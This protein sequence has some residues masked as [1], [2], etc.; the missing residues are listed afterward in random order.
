MSNISKITN[1]TVY[2]EGDGI[3]FQT[4]YETASQ[5]PCP[6]GFHI[7]T[8]DEMQFVFD[9]LKTL[10]GGTVTVQNLQDHL[11]M[12][13]VGYID[14]QTGQPSTSYGVV[15]IWT[16]TFSSAQCY[17]FKDDTGGVGVGLDRPATGMQLRPFA[18]QPVIP[19]TGWTT[20][21]SSGT[22]SLSVN[23]TLGLMTITDGEKYI[24]F[25]DKNLGATA[26]YDGTV[27]AANTGHYYQAGNNYGFDTP[28]TNTS[29]TKVN[30]T[31]YWP[32]NYYNSDT[33]ICGTNI[34]D[35]RT[36]SN[37]NLW[38]GVGIQRG[39]SINVDRSILD[40]GIKIVD[41]F[42]ENPETGDIVILS[43]DAKTYKFGSSTTTAYLCYNNEN[44]GA[45]D[46]SPKVWSVAYYRADSSSPY[47]VDE[48]AAGSSSMYLTL[49]NHPEVWRFDRYS[50]YLQSE[51]T[52]IAWVDANIDTD[53]DTD[54]LVDLKDT[55]IASAK[56]EDIINYDSS[57][58]KYVN[59][60][61]ITDEVVS[62]NTYNAITKKD[63]RIYFVTK[64]SGGFWLDKIMYRWM[65]LRPGIE[66][67]EVEDGI[68]TLQRADA[69]GKIRVPAATNTWK[70]TIDNVVVQDGTGTASAEFSWYTPD[71]S[72][73]VVVEP[74]TA[75][76]YKW[77][78]SYKR[79]NKPR[80]NSI[81]ALYQNTFIWYA[82]S[83]TTIGADYQMEQFYT[84]ENLIYI[85]EEEEDIPDTVT[86]IGN[87]FKRAQFGGCSSLKNASREKFG[88]NITTISNYFRQSQYSGSAIEVASPEVLNDK[89][90]QI[91]NYFRTQQYNSCRK[92][93]KIYNEAMPNTVTNIG[94]YFRSQQFTY[95]K[96]L[97]T[98]ATEALSNSVTSI[99][100]Y[101]RQSQYAYSGVTAASAE[102]FPNWVT[103]IW[104]SFRNGQYTNCGSLTAAAN[105]VM[106]D[107][108][109]NV[110]N[111]FRGLQ[112]YKCPALTTAWVEAMSANVSV[113]TSARTNQYNGCPLITQVTIKD[114]ATMNNSRATQFS[115]PVINTIIKLDSNDVA[116]TG[117][118][119][120]WLD[121]STVTLK[122]PAGSVET[123]Q[124]SENYPRSQF[125]DNNIVE[126]V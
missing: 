41:E 9:T 102:V 16:C 5:W 29:D 109:T 104:T 26:Y 91:W 108:V 17:A 124:Q 58:Q 105:E 97:K 39:I 126:N 7:P 10:E 42:P 19:E 33:Y 2:K 120:V 111:A 123:F 11:F 18:N 81:I 121:L 59:S 107:T 71:M 75:G 38:W 92:L 3:Y 30:T 89:V 31:G 54:K 49:K 82:Q 51:I 57:T 25:Y 8:Q 122:V 65:Q 68:I 119:F 4:L 28:I 43:T 13:P 63:N 84:C 77:A 98:A 101:F 99:A 23:H 46:L 96:S 90:T 118:P 83:S 106:P 32:G 50:F 100:G 20:V 60:Q 80:R 125:D 67:P 12:P 21:L 87:N 45:K 115:S 95:C 53:T 94:S 55:E 69:D 36:R 112:Y 103:A 62:Q 79:T 93:N 35:W 76:T 1:Y 24:T 72:Y 114:C 15:R 44:I 117:D 34:S 14:R 85:P 56:N 47:E 48:F 64:D 74:V 27:T 22:A 40:S 66:V 78:S 6:S 37:N 110:G 86:S 113:V 52:Y 88:A 61:F 73:I 116:H 70:I